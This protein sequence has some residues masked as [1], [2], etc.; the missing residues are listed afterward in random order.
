MPI[1]EDQK[2]DLINIAM[3]KF[4]ADFFDKIDNIIKESSLEEKGTEYV[5][6]SNYQGA[7]YAN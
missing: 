4:G 2:N 6:T 3:E 1:L 5:L 7:F